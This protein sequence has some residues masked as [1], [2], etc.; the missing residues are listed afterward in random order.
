MSFLDGTGKVAR[1]LVRMT[2][3]WMDPHTTQK[4]GRT[5]RECHQDPRALG[6]GSGVL[7]ST[8][9]SWVFTPA[10]SPVGLP[11]IKHPLDAFVS[12]GGIPF[13]HT[14]RPGL[15]PFN[16]DEIRSILDVGPCLDCHRDFGD[17]VMKRWLPGT[18]PEPCGVWKETGGGQGPG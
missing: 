11:G 6:L 3:S 4:N 12:I 13:V 15:R 5:C 14:S 1:D 18:P 17:P 16:R 7:S 2:V 8:D 10:L 9:K